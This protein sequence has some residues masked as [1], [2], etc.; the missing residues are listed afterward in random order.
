[1]Q[2]IL[3]QEAHSIGEN[4]LLSPT[5]VQQQTVTRVED[6]HLKGATKK[7]AGALAIGCIAFVSNLLPSDI[8]DFEFFPVFF[9]FVFKT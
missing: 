5:T 4:T 3:F 7:S 9:F 6:Y 8:F 1:M 2:I